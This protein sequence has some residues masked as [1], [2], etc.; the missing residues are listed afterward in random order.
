MG[1]II[2]SDRVTYKYRSEDVRAVDGITLNI[3]PSLGVNT[4]KV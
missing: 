1:D 2:Q 3:A 4:M